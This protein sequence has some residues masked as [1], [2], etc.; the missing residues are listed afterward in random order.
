MRQNKKKYTR[1]IGLTGGIA[2]G[3]STVTRLL[4]EFGYVVIDADKIAKEVVDV[5]KRAYLDIVKEFGEDILDE[6]NRIDRKRLGEI[7]FKDEKKRKKLNQIV[8]P[9]VIQEMIDKIKQLSYDKDVIFLDIPLLIEGKNMLEKH[10]LKFDEI[11]LVY[12][13]EEKQLS[14]LIKRDKLDMKSALNRIRAQMPMTEKL[15]VANVIIDNNRGIDELK[16]QIVRLL[17]RY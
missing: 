15:K 6:N 13:D 14:R 1:I 5:G 8:H 9:I 17:N 11:W 3:K 2:T 12:A 10:G 16:N 4:R 7:I